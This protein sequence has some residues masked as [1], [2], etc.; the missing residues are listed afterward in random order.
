MRQIILHPTKR[1]KLAFII[2]IVWG[3]I[4]AIG[5]TEASFTA[6]RHSNSNFCVVVS[7]ITSLPISKPAD[8]S[9]MQAQERQWISWER[10]K[11]LSDRLGCKG[12]EYKEITK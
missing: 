2:I 7:E 11:L 3:V 8:P 5:A 10:F 12:D 1:D 9:H 6:I 4:C